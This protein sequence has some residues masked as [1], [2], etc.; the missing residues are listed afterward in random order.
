MAVGK[1]SRVG[2]KSLR[3]LAA[4]N[5]RGQ[6]YDEGERPKKWPNKTF[7]DFLL[8]IIL[9][10]SRETVLRKKVRAPHSAQTLCDTVPCLITADMMAL[11]WAALKLLSYAI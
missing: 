2:Q 7:F 9:N 8:L 5:L 4:F 10:K 6:K 1:K 3:D 11:L